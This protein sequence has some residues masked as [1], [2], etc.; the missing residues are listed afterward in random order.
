[1]ATRVAYLETEAIIPGREKGQNCNTES[2]DVVLPD[3]LTP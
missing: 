3:V 2:P 1:M